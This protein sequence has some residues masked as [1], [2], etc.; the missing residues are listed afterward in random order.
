M[1]TPDK[2][3]WQTPTFEDFVAA[4]PHLLNHS[5]YVVVDPEVPV[6]VNPP[7]RPLSIPID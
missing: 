3:T 1:T 6:S 4:N 7:P 5:S 2:P